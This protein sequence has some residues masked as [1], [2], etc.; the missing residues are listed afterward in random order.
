MTSSC[1]GK[2]SLSCFENTIAPSA[3]TSKIPL[4]PSM[5]SASMSKTSLMRAAKLVALGPYFQRV[6]YV[7]EMSTVRS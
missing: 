7:I 1:S 2:R 4:V 6:Q 3:F 5:M